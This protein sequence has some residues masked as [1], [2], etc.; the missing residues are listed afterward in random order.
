METD[1][2]KVVIIGAKGMLGQSLVEIFESDKKYKT[3]GWDIEDIDITDRGKVFEK[4]KEAK[5]QV[6]I[7]C[8]AYNM[9][10]K[11][12]ESEE[13]FKKAN[14]I[15][16]DGP[17][18]L[19]EVCQKEKAVFVH[20]VSDYVFD[21][22]KGVYKE[23]EETNPISNYGSSKELGE[24]NARKIGG[25]YYLIRTSKLFGKPATAENA[26][27]SFFK[28]MLELAKTKKEIKVVNNERSCFTYVPDLALATKKLIED[29]QEYGVYH[30]VNEGPVTWYEGVLRL[31]QIAGI[32]DVKV[33][34]VGPDE[35][36]RSAKRPGSSV[37]I[38]TKF[39]KLR[40]YEKAIEEWLSFCDQ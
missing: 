32:K 24:K 30:L 21:G 27:K 13:E 5:P 17:G 40:S 8:A 37:L 1:K 20:Y 18:Y 26:K 12:E 15:N 2:T 35:F 16:G 23:D 7:N 39:P 11:A 29:H 34:P 19:A 6:V 31:F 14:R 38:N 10:D 36:P 9:V 25:R 3:I 33:I 4:I 28:I 22:K